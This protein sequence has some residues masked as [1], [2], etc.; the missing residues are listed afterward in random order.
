MAN[1][2]RLIDANAFRK[3]SVFVCGGNATDP[4]YN[5]YADALDKVSDAV[6][7]FPTVEAVPLGAYEQ[8]KWERD[9][10]MEQLK[11]HGIPF[12]GIAPDVVKIVRCRDCKHYDNK[13]GRCQ[14]YRM[15]KFECG[16]C[17][18][19]ERKDNGC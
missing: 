15:T 11:E 3:S 8:V 4:Y 1:E 12:G 2:R 17:D 7:S 9:Q 13:A 6:E 18:N 14:W 5:G 19:G 16:F 10:A